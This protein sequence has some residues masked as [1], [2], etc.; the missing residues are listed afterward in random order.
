MLPLCCT[1]G[2]CAR[3]ISGRYSAGGT[4]TSSRLR[5]FPYSRFGTRTIGLSSG[6]C[7]GVIFLSVSPVTLPLQLC[8]P[9]RTRV[10]RESRLEFPAARGS[11]SWLAYFSLARSFRLIRNLSAG[12]IVLIQR[13]CT[14]REI[15]ASMNSRDLGESTESFGSLTSGAE[16]R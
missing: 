8:Q 7:N 5:G 16:T 15:I 13:Q 6:M 11:I 12:V 3:E 1:V 2:R 4:S 14:T 10:P 9:A